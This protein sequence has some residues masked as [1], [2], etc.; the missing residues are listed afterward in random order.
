MRVVPP[1]LRAVLPVWLAALRTPLVRVAG[2]EADGLIG[3]PSWSVRWALEQVNGPYRD[4]LRRSGR[5]RVD[6]QN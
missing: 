3:H 6:V 4:A 5:D 2:E 1:P